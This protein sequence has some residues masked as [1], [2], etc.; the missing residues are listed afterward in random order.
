MSVSSIHQRFLQAELIPELF[1]KEHLLEISTIALKLFLL[2]HY[3][4]EGSIED[5][6]T[7]I[8]ESACD[9]LDQTTLS[10]LIETEFKWFETEQY[11]RLIAEF[12]K[13]FS[14]RPEELGKI[15]E[16]LDNKF[17]HAD[18]AVQ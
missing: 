7:P 8:I 6:G 16:Q 9:E 18:T 10:Y 15:I 2:M 17:F 5:F 12:R 14:G 11:P 3:C 1:E 4:L 13:A